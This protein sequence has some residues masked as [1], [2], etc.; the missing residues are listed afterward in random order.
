MNNK[1]SHEACQGLTQYTIDRIILHNERNFGKYPICATC[2]CCGLGDEDITHV[3]L[4]CPPF[5]ARESNYTLKSN[6]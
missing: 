3:L 4:E 6:H 2:K 5:M 1:T